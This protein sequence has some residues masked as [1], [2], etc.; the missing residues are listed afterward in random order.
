MRPSWL[1]SA[2]LL[3]HRSAAVRAVGAGADPG[4]PMNLDA[5]NIFSQ[6]LAK[7]ENVSRRMQSPLAIVGGLAGSAQARL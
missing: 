6:A 1:P 4:D 5:T 3:F 2:D 7:L